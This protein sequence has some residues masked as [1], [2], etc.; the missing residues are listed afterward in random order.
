MLV[1]LLWPGD[2]PARTRQRLSQALSS[3]RVLL[4]PNAQ[5]RGTVLLADRESVSLGDA[6]QTDLQEFESALAKAREQR[7]SAGR[8]EWLDVAIDLYHP[9]LPDLYD[10]WVLPRRVS[11]EEA[12]ARAVAE[13]RDSS[14]AA[15]DVGRAEELARRAAGADPFNE[16]AHAVWFRLL[17]QVGRAPHARRAYREL[18]ARLQS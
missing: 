9:L 8:D 5:S 6:V 14:L 1:E 11:L 2:D 17:V 16:E 15:G 4:E 13:R 10:E 3:L 12:F 7:Q 18:S